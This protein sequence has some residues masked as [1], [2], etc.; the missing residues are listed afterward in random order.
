MNST[1]LFSIDDIGI[2]AGNMRIAYISGQNLPV[3]VPI[4]NV[5]TTA[6]KTYFF[7]S[8]PYA[9]GFAR[10][11]TLGALVKGTGPFN[12]SAQVANATLYGPALI[13]V[14]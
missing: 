1:Q 13:E 11:L 8:F 10:G 7:A 2:A 6:V 14:N 9:E 5:V 4:E 12:K 3:V